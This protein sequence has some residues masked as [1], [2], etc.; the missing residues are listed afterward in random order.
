MG[1]SEMFAN[2]DMP[3]QVRLDSS[4]GVRE[5]RNMEDAR[6]LRLWTKFEEAR[7][8]VARAIMNVLSV[9]SGADVFSTMYHPGGSKASAKSIPYKAIKHL[10]EEQYS[11]TM[12]AIPLSQMAPAV[13]RE[14][15]RDFSSRGLIKDTDEAR[16]FESNPDLE[17][18]EDFELASS[19]DIDRHLEALE[20]GDYIQPDETTNLSL[21]IMKVTANKQRLLRYEDVTEDMPMIVN[22]NQWLV[23]AASIM[24]AATQPQMSQMGPLVPSQPTQGEAG[25]SSATVLHGPRG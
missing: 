2:A 20:N 16:R 13:R 14:V 15:L 11:W 6:H 5:F 17:K 9:S 24:V 22:H 19:E 10:T 23:D 4:A 7:L 18:L 8:D 12:N 3:N 1:L 25:T 21:G